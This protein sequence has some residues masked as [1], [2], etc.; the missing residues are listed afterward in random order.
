MRDPFL[1]DGNALISFSGG[2]TSAFML[3]KILQSHGGKLPDGVV[4]AFA[5]TGKEM[6]ETLDFVN[7]C[8]QRWDVPIVWVEYQAHDQPQKR[9]CIKSY[10]TASRSGEPFEALI[11]HKKYLPN[12]TMR[13]CTQEMKI[14]PM[15]LF[16]QQH[17]GWK[18]WDVVI[19]F[20]A[21]E[22]ARVA[23]LSNPHSEPFDRIA[24]LAVANITKRDISAFW[25]SQPFDLK[26]PNNN[27]TTMHGNCDL[28]FLKG[29]GQV[30][31]LIREKPERAVWWIGAEGMAQS[32][33]IAKGDGAR[34]RNDRPSYS[35]MHDMALRHGELFSF[36][37]DDISDCAC[38]D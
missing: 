14:R 16:V 31:A 2:R 28:C 35:Q 7:E 12:P 38:T 36:E 18:D 5:N 15:K 37:Q 13:F 8:S 34:F 4:V 21:D 29:A 25:N 11:R 6:P 33:G 23:K 1:V 17:L 30:L 10:E 32:S 27:G 24:P 3:W 9:W 19:G 20:R 22:P 26:L